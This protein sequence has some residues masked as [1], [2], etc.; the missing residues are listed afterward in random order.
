M[1]LIRGYTL[2]MVAPTD[3][4]I[5]VSSATR[6]GGKELQKL[7]NTFHT[8][9]FVVLSLEDTQ[10]P[11]EE[12]LALARIF[13]N[14]LPHD[15]ADKDGVAPITPMEGFADYL[16]TTSQPHLPHSDGTFNAEAPFTAILY[17]ER[18]AK[19]GGMSH[20]ISGRAAHEY[21]S[22]IDPEGLAELYAPDAMTVTRA[23]K[24][25]TRPVFSKH[26]DLTR[27]AFRYDTVAKVEVR[28]EARRAFELLRGFVRDPGNIFEFRLEPN[29]LFIVDNT[30]VL[31][32]RTEFASSEPRLLYRVNTDG[33][34]PHAL[35]YGF[36]L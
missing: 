27:I 26:E 33:S 12:L 36:T 13:G 11:K 16:G 30:A 29:Q 34:S 32:G 22:S 7:V 3:A 25:A 10:T 21:L 1:V 2:H 24:S 8:H 4:F 15:R 19:E 17:C 18:Q 6:L 31:H 23:E 5:S 14:V 28:P 35:R 9:K 20:V